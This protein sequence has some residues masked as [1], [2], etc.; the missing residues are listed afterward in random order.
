MMIV[1]DLKCAMIGDNP[2]VR[3]VTAPARA[4]LRP[5]DSDFFD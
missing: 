5:E 3:I 2:V 4:H 1:T